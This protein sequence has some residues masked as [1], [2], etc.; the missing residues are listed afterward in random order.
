MMLESDPEPNE[1][2]TF[3][4]YGLDW[5]ATPTTPIVLLRAEM[6]P[7]ACVPWP[8][9]SWQLAP[10]ALKDCEAGA[11]SVC[12]KS[13]PVSRTA[14]PIPAPLDVVV[15]TPTLV[16]PAGVTWLVVTAPPPPAP[17]S[18][19]TGRSGMTSSTLLSLRIIANA[20]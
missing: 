7:A 6:I 19:N 12:L 8:L 16:T 15:G 13:I 18:R 2:R 10:N 1:S 3:T 5:G 9:S 20:A 4:Q 14:T 17:P 11:R